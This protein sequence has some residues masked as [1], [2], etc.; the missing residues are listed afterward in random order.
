ML[1]YLHVERGGDWTIVCR[2][3]NTE[4]EDL[5]PWVKD[6]AEYVNMVAASTNA[7]GGSVVSEIRRLSKEY[8]SDFDACYDVL[9]PP[10]LLDPGDKVQTLR[11]TAT[12]LR[13]SRR[14][15]AKQCKALLDIIDGSGASAEEKLCSVADTL[16]RAKCRNMNRLGE[17]AALNDEPANGMHELIR[18][19]TD[20]E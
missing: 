3:G 4:L 8:A 6:A 16:R 15:N 13:E 11:Q 18:A 9:G 14:H 1:Q 12:K 7:S 10:S 5:N 20:I 2:Y 17:Y 19:P